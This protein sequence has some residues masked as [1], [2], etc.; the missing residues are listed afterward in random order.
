[1]NPQ[2]NN[3]YLFLTGEEFNLGNGLWTKGLVVGIIMLFVGTSIGSG[4]HISGNTTNGITNPA[5]THV[6]WNEN[7]DDGNMND[8]TIQN[9]AKP[10]DQPITL[11]LS[12]DQS[13]SPQYSML[14]DSP[15][16]GDPDYSG[17]AWGP[18]VPINVNQPYTVEFW[19]R[20][21]D[22]HKV[23]FVKFG[24]INILAD[25][26]YNPLAFYDGTYHFWG[27]PFEE[28]CQQNVWTHF[29]FDVHP[30]ATSYNMT[31]NGN[32]IAT[33]PYV[34]FEEDT[35]FYICDPGANASDY[36]DHCYYD[37]I[38]I[39]SK[40]FQPNAPTID[41]P[42]S[43]DYREAHQ[44][45][46]TA[47]DPDNDD[48]YYFVDWGD[49]KNTGWSS[50]TYNSGETMAQSHKYDAKGNYTIKA[51]AKDISGNESDWGTL[52]ITMP[53]SYNI[54]LIQFWEKL[55]ERFPNAFPILRYLMGY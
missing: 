4:L 25:Y 12:T 21:N 45:N 15:H 16:T 46:I 47:T 13:H 38:S 50:L 6:Q 52:T 5:I 32:Y 14:W 28:Y 2:D 34:A 27:P 44:W 39:Y 22:F 18:N 11:E 7:F 29:K 40:N 30:S 3:S 8:W 9:P 20:W 31:V 49:G 41:G 1:M 17:Q 19:Y 23:W 26:P 10:G 24:Y 51:K 53:C 35:R 48:I 36:F 54:P 42:T 33:C 43:G 55:L 37:D